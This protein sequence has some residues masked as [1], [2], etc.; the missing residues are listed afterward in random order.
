LKYLSLFVK[1]RQLIKNMMDYFVKFQYLF[2][3]NN[4]SSLKFQTQMHLGSNK[5][6]GEYLSYH[7]CDIVTLI[8]MNYSN[9]DQSLPAKN[10]YNN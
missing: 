6:H 4:S 2:R 8:I 5:S 1:T 7:N 3:K 9:L 10:K